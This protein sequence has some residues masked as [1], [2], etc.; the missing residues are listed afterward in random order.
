MKW[1]PRGGGWNASNRR[2]GAYFCPLLPFFVLT[3]LTVFTLRPGHRR[4][5]LAQMGTAPAVLR[6]APG[7]RFAKLLGSGAR[8]GFGLWPNLHRYALLAVWESAAAAA[9]FFAENPWWAA[10]QGRCRE[11]WTAHLA[12]LRAHGRWDG[13]QP[14]G[15]PAG[16]AA[17]EGPV[18]VLTRASIRLAKT[19]RFWRYVAPT[20]AALAEA[21]GVVL[22]LGLGE[23]PVVRQATFSVWASAAA[24]QQYA[25]H[26]A[27]HREAMR[28]TRREDW[29]SEEMF[30]RFR[31]LGAA[32]TVD[33]R[34]PLAPLAG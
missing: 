1:P 24:M 6:R 30:A 9:D 26:D 23:L 3:T 14:F 21:P 8:D 28:L 19:P 22:A 27:R 34:D 25:Y 11:T 15:E 33:G 29:Y 17:P 2:R 7:L 5:A 12:P 16:P 13:Q 4:W 31:V 32:G 18:A 10:Y 20:S